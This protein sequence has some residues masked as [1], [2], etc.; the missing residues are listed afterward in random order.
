[1]RSRCFYSLQLVLA[2]IVVGQYALVKVIACII[3]LQYIII[4]KHCVIV[5][6]VVSHSYTIS[7]TTFRRLSVVSFC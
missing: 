5:T 7:W 3:V 1:M 2:C 6:I 4:W